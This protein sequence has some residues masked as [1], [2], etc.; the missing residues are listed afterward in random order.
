MSRGAP[1]AA[2]TLL[3]AGTASRRTASRAQAAAL[4]RSVDWERLTATLA[5]RRLLPQLGERITEMCAGQVPGRFASAVE[6]AVSQTRRQAAL[7]QLVS[8]QLTRALTA[9]GIRSMILKG[10]FLG[11]AIYDDPGRRVA[12]DIDL[13]V[14]SADLSAA[15]EIA[16]T[17]GYG[18]PT[19]HVGSDGLPLLHYALAHELGQ[20]PP[21]ELHWRIHWYERSFAADMLA[22]A[23]EDDRVGLSAGLPDELTGLLLF[24]ARDGFLDLRLATDL[25]AWWDTFGARLRPGA[26]API[27]ERYPT[28]TG[29]LLASVA[30]AEG[31]VGIPADRLIGSSRRL[32]RRTSLA[33]SLADPN[34]K[35]N[36]AQLR[37]DAGLVDWLLTPRGGSREFFQRQLLVASG[38]LAERSREAERP[39]LSSVGHATRVLGRFALRIARLLRDRLQGQASTL[40]PTMSGQ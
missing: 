5:A 1:E 18:A 34:P 14:A 13:L 16:K 2:L 29:A 39:T 24:Y 15:V 32:N 21:L 37:A 6:E 8:V 38:V 20:L 12:G 23:V 19:D 10:A 9:A 3:S 28:L 33:A 25:G 17:V 22:R 30:A 11:E 36:P 7:L 35:P 4:A 26:L 31:V 27:L 40:T